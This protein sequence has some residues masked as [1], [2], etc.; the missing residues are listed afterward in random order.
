M[1][2][3]DRVEALK[4]STCGCPVVHASFFELKSSLRDR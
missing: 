2:I 1:I 4:L 3:Y